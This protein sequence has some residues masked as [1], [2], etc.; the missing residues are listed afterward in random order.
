M[1]I[2]SSKRYGVRSAG[3]RA[4]ARPSSLPDPPRCS[5]EASAGR[6][7][8]AHPQPMAVVEED[9]AASADPAAASDPAA[10][11][12]PPRARPL[13]PPL[14]HAWLDSVNRVLVACSSVLLGILAIWEIWAAVTLQQGSFGSHHTRGLPIPAAL[15]YTSLNC[16]VAIDDKI[17]DL[18]QDA[19]SPVSDFCC[20]L[21]LRLQRKRDHSRRGFFRAF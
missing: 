17:R 19:D 2:A 20:F 7:R 9:A 5:L 16:S 14:P 13:L 8:P 4:L 3:H 12:S 18:C 6:L 1:R 10:G 11:E 21:I 15:H